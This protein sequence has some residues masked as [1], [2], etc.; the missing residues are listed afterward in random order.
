LFQSKKNHVEKQTEKKRLH[1]ISLEKILPFVGLGFNIK[2]LLSFEF[3]RYR[4][5]RIPKAYW[6][7]FATHFKTDLSSIFIKCQVDEDYIWG[8]YFVPRSEHE[9]VDAVYSSMHFERIFIPDEYNGTPA[10]ACEKLQEKIDL[11]EAEIQKT[12]DTL[13]EKLEAD[14]EKLLFSYKKIS[15]ISKNFDVRKMAACTHNQKYFIVCGWMCEDDA[16]KLEKDLENIN[17]CIL[18]VE[19]ISLECRPPTKLKNPK[20]FRPFELYIKMYGLPAY[21]EFD[22]TIFVA[23]TYAFIFGAMFGDVGQGF[24]LSIGGFLL[25]RFKNLALGAIVS[26]AGIFRCCLVFFS[27]VFLVLK[28]L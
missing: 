24:L 9:E 25:Y 4:F 13:K 28:T 11:L 3:I 2:K 8:V 17:D 20:M 12:E 7:N 22:P 6:N 5:G 27:E 23:L 18:Q 21:N 1:Q 15:S 14:K 19:D 10:Y 26:T 16:K